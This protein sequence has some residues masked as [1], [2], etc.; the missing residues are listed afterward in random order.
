MAGGSFNRVDG[1]DK[2]GSGGNL[3]EV[4]FDVIEQMWKDQQD[5]P[6]AEWKL[7]KK[8]FKRLRAQHERKVGKSTRHSKAKQKSEQK[9]LPMAQ[10]VH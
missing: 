5:K 9:L 4:P 1:S 2:K 6:R 7:S 8:Q 10:G 3:A